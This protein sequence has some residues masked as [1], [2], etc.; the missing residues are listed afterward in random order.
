MTEFDSLLGKT[1]D[2]AEKLVRGIGKW[3]RVTSVN[4][5]PMV[6]TR[7]YKVDRINVHVHFGMITK[8]QGA[9]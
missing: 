3:I 7:D 6:V 1:V 5:E 8:V 9:G 4:G 2:E